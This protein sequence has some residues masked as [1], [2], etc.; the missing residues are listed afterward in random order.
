[1]KNNTSYLLVVND[2][3]YELT[4]W[5]YLIIM[6]YLRLLMKAYVAMKTLELRIKIR[7]VL[8]L[9]RYYEAVFKSTALHWAEVAEASELGWRK[10]QKL[11]LKV[12][13]ASETSQHTGKDANRGPVSRDINSVTPV[14]GELVTE[15]TGPIKVT[16]MLTSVNTVD[17]AMKGHNDIQTNRLE[18][19]F[20]IDGQP[21]TVVV[22]TNTSARLTEHVG[23]QCLTCQLRNPDQVTVGSICY[24]E[25][26][27]APGTHKT[28]T[29]K[30]VKLTLVS[31]G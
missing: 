3:V 17:L 9:C 22:Y 14:T 24:T 11:V 8:A 12:S 19:N 18:V 28:L 2:D 27:G 20:T 6:E 23:C 7:K 1:M 13:G 5:E 10:G 26:L 16:G 31:A 4:Y 21:R 29:A 25:R 15:I 30:Q